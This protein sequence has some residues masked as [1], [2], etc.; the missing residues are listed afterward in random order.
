MTGTLSCQAIGVPHDM[1]ADAG[2][3]TARRSGTRAATTF[4]KLPTASPGARKRADSVSS[5]SHLLSAG[6]GAELSPIGAAPAPQPISGFSSVGKGIG[7]PGIPEGTISMY[8]NPTS[9]DC[10]IMTSFAT[11]GPWV[12]DVVEVLIVPVA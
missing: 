9:F 4:T 6:G 7:F 2:R 3:T 12:L 11:I 8:G 1:Q 10:P 5:I